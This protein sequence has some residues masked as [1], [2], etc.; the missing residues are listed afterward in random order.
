MN[1][2]RFWR[3]HSDLTAMEVRNMFGLSRHRG[4]RQGLSKS[5]ALRAAKNA[6]RIRKHAKANKIKYH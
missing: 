2:S 5:N 4:Q 6:K 1:I 3:R